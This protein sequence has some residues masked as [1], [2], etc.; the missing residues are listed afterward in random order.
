MI[1]TLSIF[2]AHY[3]FAQ[4][5]KED[6][7]NRIV[8]IKYTLSGVDTLP[9]YHYLVESTIVID[10]R[11]AVWGI[12][13][14]NRYIP[15]NIKEELLK[16]LTTDT[17]TEKWNCAALIE[18]RCIIDSSFIPGG[19]PYYIFSKPFF[20]NKR[21]Y[22]LMQVNRGY[23]KSSIGGYAILIFNIKNGKWDFLE[24]IADREY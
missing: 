11:S 15:E 16:K 9:G 22:A 17:L 21:K 5:T 7:I 19:L 24:N 10:R 23:T 13:N 14:M 6:F 3:C 12:K 4:E 18:T 2:Y 1:L 20:D 8:Q